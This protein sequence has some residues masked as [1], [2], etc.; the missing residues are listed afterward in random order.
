MHQ[1]ACVDDDEICVLVRYTVTQLA[2]FFPILWFWMIS[3]LVKVLFLGLF[4]TQRRAGLYPMSDDG[5]AATGV[6][7]GYAQ[8]GLWLTSISPIPRRGAAGDRLFE[9][10]DLM[11]KECGT[12][13]A[14]HGEFVG[15]GRRGRPLGKDRVVSMRS[16]GQRE[17]EKSYLS[18]CHDVRQFRDMTESVVVLV[19]YVG[20]ED[21]CVRFVPAS[22]NK[23]FITA[24]CQHS[25]GRIIIISHSITQTF[26]EYGHQRS[27]RFTRSFCY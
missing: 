7:V 24:L 8:F 3:L 1:D 13:S 25:Y 27:S 15:C 2:W 12:E 23:L 9:L 19:I 4:L 14:G 10:F 5:A 18:F 11:A 22:S 21:E 20:Y 16:S 6:G 17:D 26:I